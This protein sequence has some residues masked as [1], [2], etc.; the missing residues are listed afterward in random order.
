[1]ILN[2]LLLRCQFHLIY[3]FFIFF[4]MFYYGIKVKTPVTWSL[5]VQGLF[6]FSTKFSLVSSSGFVQVFN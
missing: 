6:Y 5:C 4:K 2:G 1:M 3:S